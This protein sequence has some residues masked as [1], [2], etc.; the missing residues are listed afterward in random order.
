MR[1][2]EGREP[3]GWCGGGVLLL[4]VE[5]AFLKQA[6][7]SGEEARGGAH[8]DSVGRTAACWSGLS[9]RLRSRK[10][11]DAALGGLLRVQ[12]VREGPGHGRA[13]TAS[14]GTWAARHGD[15][16]DTAACRAGGER[17]RARLRKPPRNI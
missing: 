14:W 3:W 8:A 9:G 11:T 12:E 2:G 13:C 6:G 15:A 7:G 1:E 17:R 4:S 5:G 16:G 10:G